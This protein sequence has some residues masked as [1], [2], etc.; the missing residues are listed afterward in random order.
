ML[1][2]STAALVRRPAWLCGAVVVLVGFAIFQGSILSSDASTELQLATSLAHGHLG[3]VW[4]Q[5]R[6]TLEPSLVLLPA[7]LAQL[8]GGNVLRGFVA[9]IEFL[10]LGGLLVVLGTTWTAALHREETER[11]RGQLVLVATIATLLWVYVAKEPMDVLLAALLALCSVRALQAERVGWAGISLGALLCARDQM[12]PVA[13]LGAVAV[14]LPLLRSKRFVDAVRAGAPVLI[15][16]GLTGLVNSARYGSPTNAGPGYQHVVSYGF[17]GS[18]II[19][20]LISPQAGLLFFA[21]LCLLGIAWAW[22]R[23]LRDPGRPTSALLA[24]TLTLAMVASAWFIHPSGG[25]LEIWSW[26][27]SCRYL[28]PMVPLTAYLVPRH[29]LAAMRPLTWLA[30]GVGALWSLPMLLVPYDAQQRFYPRSSPDGPS[31]WRQFTLIP[32]VV[33]NSIHLLVHGSSPFHHSAYFVSLWQIGTV[34]SLGRASL[35]LSIP[36][37]ALGLGLGIWLVV[38]LAQTQGQPDMRPARTARGESRRP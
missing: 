32:R 19:N 29:P 7:G 8:V 25:Y 35:V 20:S 18:A 2:P 13:I 17:S 30:A 15:A 9:G 24:M 23:W 34:R 14:I 4:H 26:G 5:G 6:Y 22:P 3:T 12:I 10:V 16:L 28:V 27:R 36:L 38:Q 37:T 1:A 11:D 31:V 21:P 33:G